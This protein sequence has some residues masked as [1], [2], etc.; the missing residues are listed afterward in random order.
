MHL[1]KDKLLHKYRL[2]IPFLA[3]VTIL[4]A[5]NDTS[6]LGMELLPTTDLIDVKNLVEKENIEAYTFTEGPV[7]TDEPE[8]SLLGS[9]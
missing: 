3:V 6:D 5:C 8:K 2:F 7:Q 9:F 4:T 1:V